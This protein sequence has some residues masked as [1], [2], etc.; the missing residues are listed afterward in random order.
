MKL[1]AT[2][3]REVGIINIHSRNVDKDVGILS[4]LMGELSSKSILENS[5]SMCSSL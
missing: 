3:I 4:L 1:D 5:L 2:L